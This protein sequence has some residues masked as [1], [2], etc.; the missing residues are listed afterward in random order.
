MI[1]PS[2][3]Q[4]GKPKLK[5]KLQVVNMRRDYSSVN[6]QST[7]EQWPIRTQADRGRTHSKQ[8]TCLLSAETLKLHLIGSVL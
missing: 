3:V 8:E 7:M 6:W 4:C 2:P 5:N 1:S